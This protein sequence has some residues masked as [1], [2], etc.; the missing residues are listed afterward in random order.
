MRYR[1]F[2]YILGSMDVEMASI[3]TLLKNEKCL[4]VN[5]TT[6]GFAEVR[7][8]GA[9]EAVEE[10]SPSTV[11]IECAPY[12]G[13][14]LLQSNGAVL[15]DHHHQGDPGFDKG[16]EHYMSAASIGQLLYFM[17]RNGYKPNWESSITDA[18][19]GFSYEQR[20]AV[21]LTY[22]GIKYKVPKEY[23]Y[24]AAADHCLANAYKGACPCVNVQDL[25]EWRITKLAAFRDIKVE[26]LMLL[27]QGAEGY[28]LKCP[29]I[30]LGEYE[31]VD[32]RH[33]RIK[34]MNEAAA[35]LGLPVLA[36]KVLCRGDGEKITIQ[37][38]NSDIISYFLNIWGPSL[39]LTGMYGSSYRGIAG[40]FL[41][42][43]NGGNNDEEAISEQDKDTNTK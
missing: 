17:I 20:K 5:A 13:K 31:V 39:G 24:V 41:H 9:Y 33:T 1:S 37:S 28:L 32:A 18:N 23:R 36:S 29:M 2:T 30:N 19:D 4:V 3:Q 42:Y 14:D 11:W 22:Q 35:R 12:G 34:N 21:Y 8:S 6:N 26:S 40:G 7:S 43:D 38:S 10:P 15:I 16:P 27:V 25:K